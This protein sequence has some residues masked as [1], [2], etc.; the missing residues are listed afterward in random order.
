[1]MTYNHKNAVPYRPSDDSFLLLDSVKNLK[2]GIAVDVGTGAGFIAIN[3]AGNCDFVIGTDIDF[4]SIREARDSIRNKKIHN[5]DLIVCDLISV[6][7]DSSVDLVI[8]NPPYLPSDEYK[9]DI[10]MQTLQFYG[11]SDV[12]ARFIIDARRVLTHYGLC[13]VVY[14][15]LTDVQEMMK[16]ARTL[17]NSVEVVAEK[18]FFFER[19]YVV[20]FSLDE[21]SVTRS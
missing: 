12:I 14:S 21:H 11:K 15:S 10:D 16:N 6:L 5:I 19:L 2:T 9:T 1:M 20:K 4:G 8:F 17:F 18:S 7:K 3:I 13:Y